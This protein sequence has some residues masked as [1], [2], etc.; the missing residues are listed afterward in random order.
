MTLCNQRLLERQIAVPCARIV[1]CIT[2]HARATAAR[3]TI[4]MAFPVRRA[5]RTNRI[6]RILLATIDVSLIAYRPVEMDLPIRSLLRCDS[7]SEK[8]DEK[9]A[10]RSLEAPEGTKALASTKKQRAKH[11]RL[12]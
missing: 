1:D 2:H 11:S 4:W 3:E 9:K 7:T 6:W 10:H 5:D 8:N 12:T